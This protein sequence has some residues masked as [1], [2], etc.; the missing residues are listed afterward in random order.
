MNSWLFRNEA[1]IVTDLDKYIKEKL[2]DSV[3]KSEYGALEPEF[4][5][6]QAIID[7]R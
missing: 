6:I 1:V 3:I 7:A 2:S 4:A 5:V